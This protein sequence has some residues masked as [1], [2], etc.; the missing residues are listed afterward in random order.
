VAEENELA[1]YWEAALASL[2]EDE[3]P[4]QQRAFV[5]LTQPLGLV[6]DT[7]LVAAPNDFTKDVLE[8]RLRPIVVRA[9]TATIGQ[10]VRLAVT[11]DPSITPPVDDVTTDEMADAT[12]ADDTIDPANT[13]SPAPTA[14]WDSC[15]NWW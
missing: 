3:L 5:T 11:V 6:G 13:P 15:T 2:T 1:P 4:A 7:A 9:L 14:P 10:E 12:Y 8:T